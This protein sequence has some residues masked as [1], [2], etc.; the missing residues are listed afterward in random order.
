MIAPAL[1]IGLKGWFSALSRIELK[2]SPDG[3]TPI[4]LSTCAAPSV[5]SASANTKGFD[6]DWMVKGI[7]AVADLVD[8]PVEGGEADAEMIGVGLA[9]FGDVV[10]NRAAGLV[11][12]I[13]DDSD[14]GTA[15][16]AVSSW[17]SLAE[18][19]AAGFMSV[20]LCRAY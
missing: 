6:I 10:G 8:V 9:E 11:R 14:R 2:G 16:K 4:A 7:P 19:D 13:R 5:S 17:P 3:S 20:E 1:T 15:A 18:S 12:K